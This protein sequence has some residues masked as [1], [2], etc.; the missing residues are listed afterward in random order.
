MEKEVYMGILADRHRR[1]LQTHHKRIYINLITTGQLDEYL[2]EVE[3][4]A[5]ELR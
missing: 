4:R 2:M 3:E 5:Q 1:F